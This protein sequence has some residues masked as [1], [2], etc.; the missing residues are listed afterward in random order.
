MKYSV[1]IHNSLFIDGTNAGISE[2]TMMNMI[3]LYAYDVDFQRDIKEGDHFEIL[4]ESFYTKEVKKVKDGD[5]LFASLKLSQRNIDIY[6]HK[7][8][9]DNQYF[10]L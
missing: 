4:V 1:T 8:D 3:N 10:D 9:G 5:V 6:L 7:I 2:N